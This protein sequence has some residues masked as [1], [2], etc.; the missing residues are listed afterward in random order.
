MV[1]LYEVLDVPDTACACYPSLEADNITPPIAAAKRCLQLHLSFWKAAGSNVGQYASNSGCAAVHEERTLKAGPL[2]EGAHHRRDLGDYGWPDLE[3]DLQSSCNR[4]STF[5]LLHLL[6]VRPM[7][8]IKQASKLRR[9]SLSW[10]AGL[11]QREQS[12]SRLTTWFA[13]QT[14]HWNEKRKIEQYYYDLHK[15]D[16]LSKEAL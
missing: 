9:S 12:R 1:L 15:M 11:T 7:C 14:W 5:T 2:C 13:T 16:K 8:F 10:C 3:G 6:A 4:M